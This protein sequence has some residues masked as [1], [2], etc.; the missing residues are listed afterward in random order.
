MYLYSKCKPIF[1]LKVKDNKTP[2]RLT[3]ANQS[4]FMKHTL[5]TI[6]AFIQFSIVDRMQQI[7][8]SLSTIRADTCSFHFSYCLQRMWLS[9]NVYQLFVNRKFGINVKKKLVVTI[10]IFQILFFEFEVIISGSFNRLIKIEQGD[11]YFE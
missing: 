1:L 3:N 10:F 5:S 2:L 11:I 8:F 6:R 4:R 7:N 9:V